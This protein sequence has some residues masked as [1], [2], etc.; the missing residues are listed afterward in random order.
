MIDWT[1]VWSI[2]VALCIFTTVTA[3]VRAVTDTIVERITKQRGI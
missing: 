2:L 3:F 1:I